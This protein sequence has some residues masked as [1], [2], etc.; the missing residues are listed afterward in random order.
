MKSD[1]MHHSVDDEAEFDRLYHTHH[2]AV[3]AYCLRR[4]N[5]A[6]AYDATAEVF[7][8]AWRRIGDVPVG[9]EARWWLIGVASRVLGNQRRSYRRLA[10][11]LGRLASEPSM[12]VV[13][14]E[15]EV[16]RH[17]QDQ[18]IVSALSRLRQADQE[19]LR[20]WAW[21]ELPRDEIARLL[22]VSRPALDK[23]ITRALTRLENQL[24]SKRNRLFGSP[25]S[26]NEGGAR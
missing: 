6:S 2:R 22:D 20:L 4:A 15:A 25:R 8:V 10:R 9:D 26:A 17:E 12:P 14:P 5:H 3:L 7:V 24:A 13:G 19:V 23:R 1:P 18:Q 21:D 16:I 11:L